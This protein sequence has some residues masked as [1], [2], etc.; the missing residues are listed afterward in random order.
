[1]AYLLHF[2]GVHAPVGDVKVD[3][4]SLPRADAANPAP[5]TGAY[6]RTESKSDEIIVSIPGSAKRTFAVEFTTKASWTCTG[7]CCHCVTLAGSPRRLWNLCCQR[8]VVEAKEVKERGR[9]GCVM[10]QVVTRCRFTGH[11][12]FMGVDIAPEQLATLPNIF[13]RKFCPF[14]ACE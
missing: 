7:R 9:R 11:Y 12:L 4:K 8:S 10:A 1:R 3:G 6:W 5:R 14:C 2:H 13:S